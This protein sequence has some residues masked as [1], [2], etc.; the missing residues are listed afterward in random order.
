MTADVEHLVHTDFRGIQSFV[1]ASQQLRDV[2]GRSAMVRRVA[3]ATTGPLAKVV[4]KTGVRVIS[5]AGGQCIV[6]CPDAASARGFAAHYSRELLLEC[7][8]LDP[9]MTVVPVD[10]PIWTVLGSTLPAQAVRVAARYSGHAALAGVT[11]TRPCAVT[12]LPAEEMYDKGPSEDRKPVTR[13]VVDT[14]ELGEA[15]RGR[16]AA[17]LLGKTGVP[18]RGT[19]LG[20]PRL[21]DELGR[22]TGTR[23]LVGVVHMDLDGLGT[24]MARWLGTRPPATDLTVIRRVETAIDDFVIGLAR[25]ITATVRAAV[26]LS[27]PSVVGRPAEL[28]FPLAGDETGRRRQDQVVL[29]VLPVLAGGDDL[30]LLCDGRLTWSVLAAAFDYLAA[31]D[32]PPAILREVGLVEDRLTA[33]AGVA[34]V[35]SGHALSEAQATAGKL[36][37]RAKDEARN[38][39]DHRGRTECHVAWYRGAHIGALSSKDVNVYSESLLRTLLRDFLD[40]VEPHSLRG[41]SAPGKKNADVTPWSGRRTWLRS[42]LLPILQVPPSTTTESPRPHQEAKKLLAETEHLHGRIALPPDQD[43]WRQLALDAIDLL[44]RHLDITSGAD[45]ATTEARRSWR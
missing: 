29:P 3:D 25:H 16:F 2:V 36:C 13:A 26:D 35:S 21:V 12:G 22:S 28:G 4:H 14:R 1:F 23:S 42:R 40:P 41:E 43:D 11:I 9:V 10:G 37:K 20:F 8:E 6:L 7:R 31:P 18:G 38:R 19:T 30:T 45:R 32:N 33:C 34:V 44:D 5:A 39:A 17:D 27:G 24:R 15:Q